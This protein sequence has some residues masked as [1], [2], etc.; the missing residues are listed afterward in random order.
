MTDRVH[1]IDAMR[2]VAV[3]LVV[4]IHT[5]PFQGLGTAGNAVNFAIK[6]TAR[7]AVP[8]FF[9]VSGYFFAR[10]TVDRDPRTYLLRRTVA[11][12]S[13]Y[14]FGLALAA[15]AFFGGRL[16]TD[17]AT[18]RPV[19]RAGAARI[20]AF[21]D[22][23]ELLYYGTSVSE[24]LWFLPA[25]LFSLAFVAAFA[26]IGRPRVGLAVALCLHVVGLL[27]TSYT[28]FVD[29]PFEVRDGLFFGFFYVSLGYAIARHGWNPSRDRSGILL[30]LVACFVVLQIV[31]FS[32]LGYPLRGESFGSYVFAPSFGVTTAFLTLSLFLFLLSRPTLG[33]GTPLPSWGVYA[34]GIYVT[35]PV[36]LAAIRGLRDALAAAGWET[37]AAAF[38]HVGGTPSTVA[39][40]LG[41]YLL[42]H[43]LRIVE[44]GGSHFPG[45]PLLASRRSR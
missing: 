16:A 18:G 29:V 22:P 12:G 41:V 33:A 6:T 11:L 2:I 40:A 5:D 44:I 36:V 3:V 32:L 43:R 24:V 14:A 35:H 30:A 34:V 4:A 8:F 9:L 28:M 21:L 25:L 45:V 7:F 42:A 19:V 17:V 20:A 27:G 1:S 10:K 39:G 38:W 23:I 15:P 26:A 31:E 13:L 37:V